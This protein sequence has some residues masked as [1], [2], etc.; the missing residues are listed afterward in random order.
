MK[1]NIFKWAMALLTVVAVMPF[2]ACSN[3]EE[4]G[5]KTHQ[6]QLSV[7]LPE[8]VDAAHVNQLKL[9]KT[10]G[11]QSD[12]ISLANLNTQ[13]LTLPQGQYS[14]AITGKLKDEA[15]ATV[16]GTTTVDLY[17]DA[18]AVINLSKVRVSPL[19]FKEIYTTGGIQKYVKDPYF[20]IVNN[21]DEVQYLDGVI[22]MTPTGGHNK[23]N[24]WQAN[25]ITDK[26]ESGSGY[27]VAFPYDKSNTRKYPLQPGE[28]VVIAN[29]AANHSTLAPEGNKCPD[30]SKADW[31]IYLNETVGDIDYNVPN[32]EIIF[33]NGP[34][35]KTFGIG[36]FAKG[37]IL[38]KLPEGIAPAD[39]A[40]DEKNLMTKPGT[41][42]STP[43]LMMPS[44]YVLD[45]VDMW[46]NNTTEHHPTFLPTDDVK[47]IPAS[48]TYEGLCIRRKVASINNGIVK[49]VDTNNSSNDFL[50]NQKP[51]PGVKPTAADK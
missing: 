14:L 50:N 20:E 34:T 12:T 19:V 28:S 13:T 16:S 23:P 11:N 36:V 21:S 38:A 42:S 33:T 1:K 51:N 4:E 39:F 41:A 43:F 3:D 37:F 47:G 8:G 17:T 15:V 24:A 30:L 44:K 18:K 5:V 27:V 31:E 9:V 7:V 6:L 29:D 22:L 45:A 32:L 48:T 40:K 46:K 26:Y 10:K 49:Y 35:M 2:A 25:G